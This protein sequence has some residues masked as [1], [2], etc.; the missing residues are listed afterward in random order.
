MAK[1]RRRPTVLSDVNILGGTVRPNVLSLAS[2]IKAMSGDGVV[3]NVNGQL[4]ISEDGRIVP[5]SFNPLTN[6]LSYLGLF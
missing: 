2:K 5:V 1:G 6:P 3:T 4:W